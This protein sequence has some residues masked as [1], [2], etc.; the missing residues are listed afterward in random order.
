MKKRIV[1]MILALSMLLSIL[2]VSAFADVGSSSA[3]ANNDGETIEVKHT[4]GKLPFKGYTED[5]PEG[6]IARDFGYGQN[7]DGTY[8]L[9]CRKEGVGKEDVGKLTFEYKCITGVNAGTALPVD[10]FPM[11]G[12]PY[13]RYQVVITAEEGEKYEAGSIVVSEEAVRYAPVAADFTYDAAQ[14]KATYTGKNYYDADPTQVTVLYTP[15]GTVSYNADV[16]TTP[17][18][19][20]V[21][22]MVYEDANYSS[23][24]TETVCTFV[25]A[26]PGK[27][28]TYILNVDGA[29]TEHAE[30]EEI[31]VTAPEK[32][33]CTFSH[34][35]VTGLSGD[36][37]T[38][39]ATIR[40]K[41]PANDVKLAAK[42][43]P[44]PAPDPKP[45]PK[46]DPEPTPDPKPDPKPDP[47]PAPDP[48]PDPDPDPEPTPDPK[49]DPD[50]AP[51]P[52]DDGSG[53]VVVAAA[54][55]GGAA[56]GVGIYIAG[57]TAYLKSVLPE[58]VA[59]P[60]DRQQL[61]VALWT[62]AGKPAT[63]STA[64]FSDVA[65]DAAELQ[66]IRWA[67]D[68]GLMTAQDGSFKPGNRVSRLEVI[69]TWK[70]YQKRD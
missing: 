6:F 16:P 27:P 45:D 63:Q 25:V 7:E 62:A 1:S 4:T 36:V 30:G 44:T 70:S 53:A 35:E 32:E 37:D 41:M 52:S 55:V 48:K 39:K 58:G 64:L 67:V 51:A 17:G 50:P 29:T 19:Y 40:F 5:Y 66:A 31:I 2:P 23:S 20:D 42:I 14:H 57:T 68:T 13:G 34:W 54:A 49:P 60:A 18:R 59:I 61:A 15:E 69:R 21:H 46:P 65:A 24:L 47:E 33:G 11:Q 43:I 28:T 9:T 8:M 38:T 10:T 22:V 3:A 12:T 26:D 56:V